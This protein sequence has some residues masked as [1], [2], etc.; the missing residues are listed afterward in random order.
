[1]DSTELIY[2][3]N[4][5]GEVMAVDPRKLDVGDKFVSKNGVEYEVKRIDLYAD[6]VV[7]TLGSV[8]RI[9]TPWWD[10]CSPISRASTLPGLAPDTPTTTNDAGDTNTSDDKQ[11]IDRLRRLIVAMAERIF[12][13]S[14][15]LSKRAEKCK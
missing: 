15:L 5:T 3:A 9:S 1:M 8:F 7:T 6:C 12:G 13:Q 11:E 2:S 10:G 4:Y 14:E